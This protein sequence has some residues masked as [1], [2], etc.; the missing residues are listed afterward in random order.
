MVI[1][2]KL[3]A[4]GYRVD[5]K[6]AETVRPDHQVSVSMGQPYA[7]EAEPNPDEGFRLGSSG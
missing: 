5:G 2:S 6:A 3:P 7:G 4:R 1:S